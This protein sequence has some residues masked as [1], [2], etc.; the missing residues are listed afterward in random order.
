MSLSQ[1]LLQYFVKYCDI[2]SNSSHI[3]HCT[4]NLRRPL[5]HINDLLLTKMIMFSRYISVKNHIFLSKLKNIN[6]SNIHKFNSK[7]HEI[8]NSNIIF[9]ITGYH[10]FLANWSFHSFAPKRQFLHVLN[11]KYSIHFLNIPYPQPTSLMPCLRYYTN[12]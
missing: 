5:L 9:Q 6:I 3:S 11:L 10:I 12:R 2:C 4:D 1:Y 7:C 8:G